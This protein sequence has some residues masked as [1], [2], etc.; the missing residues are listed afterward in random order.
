MPTSPQ[1]YT[2]KTGDSLSLIAA[3]FGSSVTAI[4]EANAA[5]YPTLRTKPGNI[6]IGWTLTIPGAGTATQTPA[7]QTPQAQT[8]AA[9]SKSNDSILYVGMNPNSTYE[10]RALKATGAK[11]TAIHDAAVPDHVKGPDGTTY[12]LSTQEGAA[13]FAATFKL[14]EEQTAEVANAIYSAY[15][16]ARDEIGQIAQVWAAAERGEPMPSRLVLSGHSVGQGVWGEENGTLTLDS[17]GRLA[18]V[19]PEAARQVEDLHIAGCYSGGAYAM[20]RLRAIFPRVKTIWAYAGTAPAAGPG[21]AKH[22]QLWE[23]ATRGS[24]TDLDR[25]IA[26]HTA[27]GDHVAVWTV[28][29]GYQDGHPV[30]DI[31]S[32]RQDFD[33]WVSIFDQYFRGDEEM[34]SPQAGPLRDYY[35]ALQALLQHP[36]L[37]ADERPTLAARRD[38]TIRLIYYNATVRK[39]F[40]EHYAG[41]IREGFGAL[42]LRVP[43]FA[44][45]SRGEALQWVD[46]FAAALAAANP[47]P[48]AAT[49]LFPILQNGLVQLEPTLIPDAWV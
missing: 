4:V 9:G 3:R 11:V 42:D 35:N 36:D 27:A 8:P 33:Y 13:A 10:D 29:R 28:T 49:A 15:D 16:D 44:S 14:S 45:L 1:S 18:D 31:A 7:A 34:S 21:A 32:V 23:Q 48:A 25:A 43:D 20:E 47:A 19:M 26:A 2:V 39:Q 5:R 38:V 24:R 40:A 37:P 41:A 17:L 30:E 6:G 12:D 22:E 46:R